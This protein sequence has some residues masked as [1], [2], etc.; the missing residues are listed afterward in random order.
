MAE[1]LRYGTVHEVFVTPAAAARHADLLR[2]ASCTVSPVTERAAASLSDTVT[3]QGIVAVCD[4][5]DVALE[6]AIAEQEQLVAVLVN[7]AD[8]GNAGTVLRVADAAGADSV[9]FAGDAVD[10][11]N[12]KSVRASAGSLFHTRL[13]QVRD[14][15]AVL[16]ACGNVGL[17]TLAT[18]GAAGDDVTTI[19][20]LAQPTA[21]LFGSEAHGLPSWLLC[22]ADRVARVPIYGKAESLNLATAA[23]VSL[24][25][26][27]SAR[28]TSG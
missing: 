7:V 4:R 13:A 5:V 26:S 14:I 1:A 12:G 17:R 9:V 11:H 24:Y 25:A 19:A 28:R 23:A 22:R 2:T 15:D 18:D 20:G 27:A 10:A 6:Q 3:P 16:R 8:P 21:W